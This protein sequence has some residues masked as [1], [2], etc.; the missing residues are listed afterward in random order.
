MKIESF[1]ATVERLLPEYLANPADVKNN[2]GNT[3]ICI[4]DENGQV[5]GKIFGKDKIISRNIFRI[6]WTKASQVWIT[7]VNTGEYEKQVFNK[8][9]DEHLFGIEMPDLIGWEGGQKVILKDGTSL[10]V[11]FSGMRGVSDLEIVTRA[12]GLVDA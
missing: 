1:I 8:Q 7:G 4:I 9:I 6:A 12:A 5:F 10:S 3:A 2:K 11:G